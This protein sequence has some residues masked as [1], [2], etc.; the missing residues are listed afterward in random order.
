MFSDQDIMLLIFGFVLFYM[1]CAA[2]FKPT[3]PPAK[4]PEYSKEEKDIAAL[5]VLTGK[6]ELDTLA[7]DMK[8]SVGDVGV[9]IAEYCRESMKLAEGG[10]NPF[11]NMFAGSDIILES[12]IQKR[13]L[14]WFCKKCEEQLGENWK[15][16][17][18]Y[19]KR[20]Q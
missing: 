12:K 8:V 4:P 5:S 16:I 13:Q 7:A 2:L 15:D 3:E 9:W 6:K 17:I 19:N 11:S 14:D 20:P 10:Y 18:E 1:I